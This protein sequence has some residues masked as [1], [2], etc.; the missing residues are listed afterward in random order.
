MMTE[1]PR[2]D[3][4][5]SRSGVRPS[6][7]PP[8][9]RLA[10][11]A[12]NHASL[13]MLVRVRTDPT[14]RWVAYRETI[15]KS[16]GSPVRSPDHRHQLSV[17]RPRMQCRAVIAPSS[18]GVSRRI[19]YAGP[20][21]ES[22][23]IAEGQQLVASFPRGRRRRSTAVHKS[24][25]RHRGSRRTQALRR[26]PPPI[27][28]AI[29]MALTIPVGAPGA[30]GRSSVLGSSGGWFVPRILGGNASNGSRKRG[31]G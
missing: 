14:P 30:I 29:I 4:A 23:A 7:G 8:A 3:C 22:G 26:G 21:V 13:P 9:F 17:F 19:V 5:G 16:R 24:H 15:S 11:S 18:A 20:W 2:S 31:T 1:T 12:W 10:V 28:N 27:I 25:G 6:P